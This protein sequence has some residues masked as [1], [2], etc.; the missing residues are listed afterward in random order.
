RLGEFYL[1]HF[2]LE[3]PGLLTHHGGHEE[4]LGALWRATGR[5]EV[6]GLAKKIPGAISVPVWTPGDRPGSQHTPP[7][8]RAIGGCV[9]LFLATGDATFLQRA[10]A[11]WAHVLRHQ[12]WVTGGISEGSGYT[13]ETCD[14]T[15]SVADW[16]RLSLKLWQA[17]QN[18]RYMD[19]AELV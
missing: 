1:A 13:F 8:L 17:T 3:G 9:D 10:E 18:P 5:D 11:V 4:G 2:P 7:Y 12:M 15:C 14:E 19:V 16:L 6:L